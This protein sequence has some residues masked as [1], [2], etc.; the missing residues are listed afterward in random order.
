MRIHY[1]I[2][3]NLFRDLSRS[4]LIC[5]IGFVLGSTIFS[6]SYSQSS[7]QNIEIGLM[8]RDKNDLALQQAAE[9]AII[10][11]NN[12]GGYR[13]AKF[14][15]VVKSCDGPWGI[16]SK[17]A[18]D[19]INEDQVPIVVG[20]L[21]GRNAHLVEQVTAKS[22]VVML[23]TLSSDPTL[24]RAYVPWFF[25]LVPDDKQQAEVLVN[26]IY[27]KDKA[28]NIALISLDNYD[29]KMS[30]DA[31]LDH[32][33]RKGFPTPEIFNGLSEK[34]LL[35]IISKKS[36]DAVVLAGT[37]ENT[38]EMVKQIQSQKMY[39]FLN[40]FNFLRIDADMDIEQI[41]FIN[42]EIMDSTRWQNFEKAFRQKHNKGPAPSLAYVYDGIL[43]ACEAVKE[44][45]PDSEA[46]RKGFK[47]LKYH[48]VTGRIEFGKLGNREFP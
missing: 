27:L 45:G 11:A 30:L 21:D 47:A 48:G 15:L 44:F 31:F 10:E 22:H 4:G 5:L 34:E 7:R 39:A 38:G 32:A 1:A 41:Q 33:K 3:R 24:S 29:G 18:V 23:S 36:W 12:A 8:V 13:G 16:G 2:I 43:M 26:Q 25:R 20:A 42:H 9:L 28:R 35:S 19:L 6:I 14:E 37:A 46:I 17:Q 40:V